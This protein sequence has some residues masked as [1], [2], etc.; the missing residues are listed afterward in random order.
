M[1]L[2]FDRSAPG[3]IC[4]ANMDLKEL[5]EKVQVEGFTEETPLAI[6]GKAKYV[7]DFLSIMATTIELDDRVIVWLFMN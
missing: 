2:D 6:Y 3:G 4:E 7:F 1:L 5:I